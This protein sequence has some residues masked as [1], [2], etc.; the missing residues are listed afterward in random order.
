MKLSAK[1]LNDTTLQEYMEYQAFDSLD[2][3]FSEME[4]QRGIADGQV[5]P[6]QAAAKPGDFYRQNTEL[7]F[8]IYGKILRDPEPRPERLKH[9]RFVQAYSVACPEGEMGDVHVS[10][11]DEIISPA[12]FQ[13]AREMGWSEE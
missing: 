9:Y 12:V 1:H 3:M 11:I 4:R 10:Q 13:V 2:D 8:P 7:G 5:Q 6:Y